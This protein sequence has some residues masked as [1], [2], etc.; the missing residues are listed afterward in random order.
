LLPQPLIDLRLSFPFLSAAL[1]AR[2]AVQGAVGTALGPV[3]LAA[4][5][6]V[7]F[8][9]AFLPENTTTYFRPDNGFGVLDANSGSSVRNAGCVVF[10]GEVCH[11]CMVAS[12][13]ALTG[14]RV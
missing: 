3:Y 14:C 13:C 2:L 7:I 6:A 10:F 1:V 5:N 8:F 9:A 11:R 12:G 4:T